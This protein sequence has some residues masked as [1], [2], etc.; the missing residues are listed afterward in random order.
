MNQ[1]RDYY[2]V[3]GVPKNATTEEIKSSYRK[4]ALKYHP[5]KNQGEKDAEQKFKEAAEAYEVLSDT[6]KRSRYDRFG[7]GGVSAQGFTNVHDIFSAF[8][9]IFGSSIFEDI[10][11][12]FGGIRGRSRSRRG[13]D[14]RCSVVLDFIETAKQVEKTITIQRRE[15]CGEC[16]GTGCAKGTSPKSC[17]TCK[18]RGVIQQIQGFFSLQI[19]C[20]A[21]RG[22]AYTIE[23]PCS[24]CK[25]RGH[26][27]KEREILVKI[28]AGVEENM[29]I[30]ITEE[31]EALEP[32]I[33]RGDLYCEV[34]V[35]P[36]PVFQR[37]GDD[38][39]LEFPISFTQAA[40]GDKVDVPT[41][42]G[43]AK[44]TIPPGTQSHEVFKLGGMGFPNIR[45][46]GK[47]NQL[48]QVIVE[49][50][51]KLTKEQRTLLQEFAKLEDLSATPI[52]KSFWERVSTILSANAK[53]N[54][55]SDSSV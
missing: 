34:E 8:G 55:H 2:E 20:P 40:L 23:K 6:E 31:G 39:L 38:V 51:K 33:P 54:S 13:N 36:H 48:I 52:K 3:L 1:K 18:G 7:H 49:V 35:R 16:S 43:K 11:G 24:E 46:R 47:G 41:I 10:F 53:A 26:V 32:G 44:L 14:I 27:A 45:G 37:H 12:G 15:L 9:D 5:D 17:T 30:R 28:P 25:G 4:L 50:P 29:Q 21:C 19:T 22:Q 42:Y